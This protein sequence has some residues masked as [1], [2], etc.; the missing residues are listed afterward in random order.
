MIEYFSANNVLIYVFISI[1]L[2]QF[3]LYKRSVSS[4]RNNII[5]E[6]SDFH[7][8]Q[9][10]TSKIILAL[11]TMFFFTIWLFNL[12]S[13]VEYRHT[14]SVGCLNTVMR[15][16]L[17]SGRFFPLGHLEF[18]IWSLRLF[19]GKL[20]MLFLLPLI[21]SIVSFFVIY[22]ILPYRNSIFK[23]LVSIAIFISSLSVPF[24]NLIIPERNQIFFYLLFLFFVMK[25]DRLYSS[26]YLKLGILFGGISFFY[27][28]P[29]FL[30]YLGFTFSSAS[31]YIFKGDLTI[32]DFFSVRV[33]FNILTLEFSLILLA[34][35]YL[36]GYVIYVIFGQ[37]LES[38]YSLGSGYNI[39]NYIILMPYL[40]LAACV[41]FLNF[42]NGFDTALSYWG[43]V[44]FGSS[45]ACFL[46][47]VILKMPVVEYYFNISNMALILSA[48]F[49]G[50]DFWNK[51]IVQERADA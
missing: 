38:I 20:F 29:T 43:W 35:L 19:G 25:S 34:L 27:K 33:W 12:F 30:L 11:I 36:G 32:K 17:Y 18:N 31:F 42:I 21:Q 6:V 8:D 49:S 7:S 39:R 46:G 28:E 44:F 9:K 50:K 14:D 26:V 22:T 13:P 5:V 24:S 41:L 2:P 37:D 10:N 4:I 15:P 1:L 16:V 48:L 45:F 51:F 23:L 47:L 40:P 3:F